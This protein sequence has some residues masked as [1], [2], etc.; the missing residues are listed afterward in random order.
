MKT[1]AK[2]I[3][4]LFV[5]VMLTSVIPFGLT[6][7][8][9]PASPVIRIE[10]VEAFP[11]DEVE[12]GIS[13]ENNPGVAG[14]TLAV[15][16][17][18]AVLTW[19]G[20][21]ENEGWGGS[22]VLPILEG[23]KTTDTIVWYNTSDYEVENSVFATLAFTVN[24]GIPEGLIAEVGVTY[25]EGDISDQNDNNLAPT[26]VKGGVTVINYIA[27]D[28]NGD[29]TVNVKD[30]IR[31][32]QY[33]AKWDVAVVE[34]V[35]D[36]NGD[37]TNN[38]KDLIRLA[39]Y[40]AK[41]EVTIFPEPVVYT[42][43]LEYV[44]NGDGTCYVAGIGE[45]GD[46]V[47]NVP[48]IS[49]A[50]DTV[51]GIGDNAFVRNDAITSVTVPASVTH[52]GEN[53]FGECNNI[54]SVTFMPG[55]RLESIA[56]GA[57][58]ANGITAIELPEGLVTIGDSAFHS[59]EIKNVFIPK[60]VTSIG[61]KAF[62]GWFTSCDI[63]TITVEEG[64]P[65]YHSA[66][67]CLIE[68]ES[69]TL[70]LGCNCSVIPS[71]GSVTAIGD[72][73][74][75][76]TGYGRHGN[77]VESI[78]IP[79]TVRSIGYRAFNCCYG[80]KEVVFEGSGL[81]TIGGEAFAYTPLEQITIPNS[82][83]SI[84]AAAFL[85]CDSLAEVYY[86]G[87]AE[88]WAAITIGA[89]NE[90]LTN[91]ARVYYSAGLE[92]VSNGDGTCSVSGI[93]TCTETV[94]NIPPVSPAG[95]VVTKIGEGAFYIAGL[96][97]VTIPST[98]EEIDSYAFAYCGLTS[99]FIPANVATVRSGSSFYKCGSLTEITVDEE[100]PVYTSVDGVVYTKDM[101]ELVCYPAGK[102]ETSFTV[103]DSVLRIKSFEAFCGNEHLTNVVLPASV[104]EI[105][106]AF[107]ECTGLTSVAI[108]EGNTRIW[109]STFYNCTDLA[110]VAIP[111]S[112]TEI[113]ERAFF[114]CG[115]L[116]TVYYYGTAE[117]WAAI[118]VGEGN[119]ALTNA[120]VVFPNLCLAGHT[121]TEVEAKEPTYEE[122]GNRQY[123][124]CP[125]CGRYFS[126]SEG[127]TEIDS[128]SVI[129]PMR[130]S[131]HSMFMNAAVDTPLAVE[132]YVQDKY[133][134]SAQYGNTCLFLQDED[135]GYFVYRW[136]CTQEEYDAV[137]VGAKV[138]V[139]G[140]K[141]SWCGLQEVVDATV[142][143]IEGD[144]LIFEP[145]DVTS[146]LG[147]D[148]ELFNYQDMYVI[149]KGVTVAA[150]DDSGAAFAYQA[151][152]GSDIYYKVTVNDGIYNFCVE[153]D[154]RTAGSDAYEAVKA[155]N[156]GDVVDIAGFLYWNN[157][158]P[159]LQTTGVTVS[160]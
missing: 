77:H 2:L 133:V 63:E 30:L 113:G 22:F 42:S 111:A 38:V 131:S 84:G 102:T 75:E 159:C 149:F 56:S 34:A 11:G 59:C 158:G 62:G 82:V 55:S 87:T 73:A 58:Y 95:D 50:G 96:T 137:A 28:I 121:L 138:R 8:A 108:P 78:T 16:Y 116:T 156:A 143:V 18:S 27:G 139:T 94:L 69:K 112:V 103:P 37:G 86:Y 26:V 29:R 39:Q 93:G 23:D 36:V 49:P 101:T 32:A 44:S 80:L 110:S 15:E 66:G 152:D 19:T 146:L 160:Q 25:G 106:V 83:T 125:V 88:Q 61:E 5:A 40:L 70:I 117:Q 147:T 72:H 52:I 141:S 122:D 151:G 136:K 13:F 76:A 79:A 43:G 12:I 99:V 20:V 46:T 31:L 4:F 33:I 142:E 81:E 98:V 17:N 65:V 154:L 7:S 14:M 71:D 35:L 68:T 126:D 92:Y 54:E 97:G 128:G 67:N 132:A 145:V 135:G 144:E 104:T 134:Y 60:S 155:L 109:H 150:Y 89:D 91:A 45:S 48:S 51:T 41:W 115:S 153:S 127:E 105:R 6:V 114:G 10:S 129:I 9:D 21:I 119:E 118:T 90:A 130:L 47:L 140:C 100:N 148:D 123:W 1:R 24:E 57:F 107:Y 3:S 74:F 85:Y 157:G 120:S 124:Y 53:A 64:N